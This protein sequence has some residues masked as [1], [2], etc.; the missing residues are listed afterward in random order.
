MKTSL[1]I[2]VL[3]FALLSAVACGKSKSSGGG[4]E[5]NKVNNTNPPDDGGITQPKISL[6]FGT[7]N[8]ASNG[9]CEINFNLNA[10]QA[11]DIEFKWATDD[12]DPSSLPALPAGTIYGVANTHYEPKD[13]VLTIAAGS[14]KATGVFNTIAIPNVGVYFR[15]KVSDCKIGGVASN[16]SA[17]F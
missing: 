2:S 5:D 13:G 8:T 16:C 1:R 14:V 6:T 15:F 7:C 4:G 17:L 10:A 11:M 3:L 12:S 9:P